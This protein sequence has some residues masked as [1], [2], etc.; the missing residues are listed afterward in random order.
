MLDKAF[1][2]VLYEDGAHL[3]EAIIQRNNTR[4]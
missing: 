2:L 3:M 1:G 4:W